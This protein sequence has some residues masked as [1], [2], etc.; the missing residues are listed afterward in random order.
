MPQMGRIYAQAQQ[1]VI[2]LGPE[3]HGSCEA[4]NVINRLAKAPYR[5]NGLQFCDLQ[6]ESAWPELGSELGMEP[7]ICSEEWGHYVKF[8]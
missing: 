8:S 7:H 4:V 5:K 6:D 3:D 1:V 2:W